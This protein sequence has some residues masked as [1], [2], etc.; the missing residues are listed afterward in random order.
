MLVN[1]RRRRSGDEGSTLVSVLV[2]VMVLGL[3]AVTLA[4]AVVATAQTTAG[5][6]GSL[7]S[8]AASDAGLAAA[9][10][11]ST[12]TGADPCAVKPASTSA[13]RYAV[14]ASCAGDVVTFVSTGTGSDGSRTVTSA[15]YELKKTTTAAPGLGADMVFFGDATFTSEVRSHELDDRLLTIMMPRGTFVCQNHVPANILAGGNVKTNGQCTIDGTVATG[16]SISMS[17]ASDTIKGNLYASSTATAGISGM[18]GGDIHVGGPIDFG[19]SGFTYPGN[20]FAGGNVDMTSVSIAGKLTLPRAS[21]VKLDGHLQ[22]KHPTSAHARVAK[23]TAGG[24]QWPTS[25]V[26]P[27][28]PTFQSWFDYS[29]S[30]SHWPGFT[31]KTLATSGDGPWTC[32]RFRNNNP[33]TGNA[34]GW[35]ELSALTTPTVVD[36]RPC[37]TLSSNN[38]SKPVV[39]LQTDIAFLANNY[40]ITALTM[41]AAT[42]KTPKVWWIVEDRIADGAPSCVSPA[43]TVNINTTVMGEGISAM[44]YTPCRISITGGGEWHGTFYGGGLNHGGLMDFY[45][46]PL[47]L[48]GQGGGSSGPGSTPGGGTTTVSLGGLLSRTDG[49]G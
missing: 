43:G 10:A 41:K 34:A 30:A 35:R 32:N 33:S 45:G 49:A 15:S 44:I 21:T 27:T 31:V 19:W 23:G 17:N 6:R 22:V 37:G 13:P 1:A 8:Q 7:D 36:A 14:T 24:L 25:T 11:S 2:I 5:V 46:R 39:T 3:L 47:L 29:Y 16:G 26:P 12:A 38:G 9:V 18:I 20:V 28:A 42:G 40:D 4:G 48:P